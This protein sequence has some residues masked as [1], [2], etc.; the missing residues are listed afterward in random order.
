MAPEGDSLAFH[1]WIQNIVETGW[2]ETGERLAAPFVSNGHSYPVTDELTM[3]AVGKVLAPLTGGAAPA[4]LWWVILGFPLAAVVGVAAARY[5][6]TSRLVAVVP[7]VA[8]A[9]L[10]DH[11]LRATGHFSLASIWAMGL[12]VLAALTLL[13]REGMPR[14]AATGARDRHDRGLCRRQPHQHLLRR[15]HRCARHGCRHR[16]GG[17]AAV[18]AGSFARC[19]T[20]RGDSHPCCDRSL[21]RQSRTAGPAGFQVGGSDPRYTDTE[22]FGGKITAMLLPAATHR[23][24]ALRE[25][26][27]NYDNTFPEPRRE[28][29]PRGRRNDRV[30]RITRLVGDPTVGSTASV[31]DGSHVGHSRGLTWVCVVMFV[32]GGFG[33]VWALV[34]GGVG[35]RVWS[36]MHIVIALAR[37]ASSGRRAGSRGSSAV[38]R[39]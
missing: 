25:A 11:F 30:L 9:L 17:G 38:S 26:R 4:V 5:L 24:A 20:R 19:R 6:G 15:V 21:R 34:L 36:R 33:T 10:P 23:F 28:S 39:G 18:G 1:A 32:V 31:R 8:F 13:G 27:L 16:G 2:Y 35:V 37:P 3:F 14:Q 22:V 29:R 12:G 7:G